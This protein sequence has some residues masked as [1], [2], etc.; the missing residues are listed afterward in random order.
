VRG[1]FAGGWYTLL[2]VLV[3]LQQ[4]DTFLELIYSAN[5]FV[6]PAAE[7]YDAKVGLFS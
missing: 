3:L 1:Y 4:W 2:A 6:P 7:G 5:S